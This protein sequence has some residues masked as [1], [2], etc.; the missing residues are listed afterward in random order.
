VPK[1]IQLRHVPDD[2]HRKL[3]SR[4]AMEGRSLSDYIIREIRQL[5]EIPTMAEMMERLARLKPVHLKTSPV[6]ILR[7]S[8]DGLDRD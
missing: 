2:L 8:R 4:A 3:K 7:A 1:T 5:E 6:E